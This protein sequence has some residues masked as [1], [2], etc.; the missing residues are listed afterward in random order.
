[1]ELTL[2]MGEP[3]HALVLR[4]QQYSHTG[5]RP[6]NQDRFGHVQ[7]GP[8]WCGVVADGAGGHQAGEVAASLAVESILNAWSKAPQW[9]SSNITDLLR[10]A[11]SEIVRMQTQHAECADMHSTVSVMVINTLAGAVLHA[12]AGDSRIYHFRGHALLARTLDHSVRQWLIDQGQ[13][14]VAQPRNAL[15]S[16][17]G[18]GPPHFVFSH[19]EEPVRVQAGDWFLMCSDGLWGYFS[20]EELALLGQQL[21]AKQELFEHMHRLVMERA[22][23]QAD[24]FTGL[25]VFVE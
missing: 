7:R 22:K 16:A 23:G 20:E 9:N 19:T 8:L 17:L 24:N 14:A 12:H 6:S 25:A 10:F 3:S 1:M 4:I 21:W 18:E 13:A 2:Q 15:Y 11:N 5:N